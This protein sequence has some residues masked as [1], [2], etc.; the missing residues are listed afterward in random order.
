[1]G[2]GIVAIAII[3]GSFVIYYGHSLPAVFDAVFGAILKAPYYIGQAIKQIITFLAQ[4]F[5]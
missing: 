5:Q 4:F 1:M 2:F 3:W